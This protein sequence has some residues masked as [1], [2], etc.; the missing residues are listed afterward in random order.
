MKLRPGGGFAF[1][2]ERVVDTGTRREAELE[3]PD[4]SDDVS[5]NAGWTGIS[6]HK[7]WSAPVLC[8]S[9]PWPP[10][11]IRAF[12][13]RAARPGAG[14]TAFLIPVGPCRCRVPVGKVAAATHHIQTV[15]N[16]GQSCRTENA[17]DDT[18]MIPT[19]GAGMPAIGPSGL[20]GGLG[21]HCI[22]EPVRARRI[23]AFWHCADL[24]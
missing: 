17:S 22:S 15:R 7:P 18:Q 8:G 16:W 11:T 21:R 9:G 23:R 24:S 13:A 2:T 10:Q 19:N 12:L 5:A 4:A 14:F 3:F 1:F 20:P 6:R